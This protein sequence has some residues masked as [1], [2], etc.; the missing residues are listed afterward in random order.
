MRRRINRT[1]LTAT[2]ASVSVIT[3]SFMAAGTAGAATTA[4][5][6]NGAFGGAPIVTD[7]TCTLTAPPGAPVPSD[8]C[9]RAG[10]QAS[11]RDFRYAAASIVVPARTGAVH[12]IAATFT[13]GPPPVQITP[14]VAGD[15][16]MYVALDDSGD[17]Y[18]YA[19]VGIKPTCTLVNAAGAC[20][21]SIG[22]T[23]AIS[24]WSVFATVA[25]NGAVTPITLPPLPVADQGNGIS[26]SAYL[27][28]SSNYV[29]FVITTPTVPATV[30]TP[31]VVGQTYTRTFGVQGPAYTDAQAAAD[32]SGLANNASATTSPAQPL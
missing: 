24:S 25:I 19:R 23:T 30:S 31:G 27:L 6:V 4:G 26:V 14:A 22:D 11:G 21:A 28:P 15:A 7:T 9:A 8:N 1:L 32:W 10:Y 5:P 3:L 16:T 2:A 29:R 13:V 12:N 17:I 18:D 20:V